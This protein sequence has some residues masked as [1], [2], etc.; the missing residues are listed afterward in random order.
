[1]D[2]GIRSKIERLKV[3]AEL[4]LDNNTKVFIKTIHND[5]YF[6]DILLVGDT[7]L[8]VYNFAGKRKGEK[9]RLI[10][11]D[12]SEIFEYKEK[13]EDIDLQF[14]EDPA[15]LKKL[16]KCSKKE[17]LA[18]IK[19]YPDYKMPDLLSKFGPRAMKIIKEIKK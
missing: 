11:T 17:V 1:M 12:I 10:W 8:F 18:Y 15:I 16:K 7:Y 9:D 3:K 6:C 19:K 13:E 4:L 14:W 2:E 5:Y